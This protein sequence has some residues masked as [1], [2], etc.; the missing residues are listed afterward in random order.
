M[1]SFVYSGNE[2]IE[3]GLNAFFWGKGAFLPFSFVHLG[4]VIVHPGRCFCT[5]NPYFLQMPIGFSTVGLLCCTL[6]FRVHLHILCVLMGTLT[7]HLATHIVQ[8]VNYL[9]QMGGIT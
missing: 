3:N 4:M 5:V 9:V 7:V 8:M 6:D 2:N 1:C